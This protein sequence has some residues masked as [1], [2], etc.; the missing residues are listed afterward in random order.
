[1]AERTSSCDLHIEWE[2]LQ[3]YLYVPRV[4]SFVGGRS[5]RNQ[6]L[7]QR[8]IRHTTAEDRALFR[9]PTRS[10]DLT[11][12]YFFLIRI[13]YG[14]FY[15]LY[16]SIC[17]RC[18]DEPWLPSQKSMTCCSGC[19]GNGL[20]SW[21]LQCQKA[22]KQSTYEVCRNNLG[23][24][25]VGCIRKIPLSPCLMKEVRTLQGPMEESY[26]RLFLLHW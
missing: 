24:L 5:Y 14:L 18:E 22:K 12:R 17:L 26:F 9:W 4:L 23:E 1:M 7:A 6:H 3:I 11:T 25:L 20:S 21:C 2:T 19:F 16:R 15:R 13:P 10:P 8:W